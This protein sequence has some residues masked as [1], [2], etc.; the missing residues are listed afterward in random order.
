MKRIAVAAGG[1]VVLA[2]IGALAY[3]LLRAPTSLVY[4]GT[5]ETREIEVGSKVG[6]RVT[7]VGAEEGQRVAAST[8][9]VL[10]EADE[11]KAQLAQ[12]Q[13]SVA[14]AEADLAKME[15]GNRPEEIAQAQATARAQQ[16]AYEAAINGPRTQELAQAQADYDAAQADAVNAEATFKRM[17]ML[18]RGETISR[19]QYDDSLAKRDAT[20]QKAESARQRLKLLQAG[21]RKEDLDAAEQRY[22]Q[23]KAAA[24]LARRGFRKEDIQ[25]ARG[26]LEQAKGHVNELQA[27]LREAELT[28]PADG[29]IETVSVRSG[30]LVPAGRIVMTMLESSQLWVR[31]YIPETEMAKV[32]VGQQA[33]VTVDSFGGKMFTGHLAQINASSEFLPRN[34]QTRDD[35]QHQVFGAKVMIDNP[36]GVLKSGMAATVHLP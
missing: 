6:G 10:F 4:S 35:R 16:A 24:D 30:D 19:Q 18:V 28:A 17:A 9:L 14:Q 29:L 13:A 8:M 21:T 25:E 22:L 26:R 3:W 20:A 32:K 23:A 27:R 11:L 33:T 34:V 1:V 7:E 31:I 36:D 5:V 15:H 2:V 12:A